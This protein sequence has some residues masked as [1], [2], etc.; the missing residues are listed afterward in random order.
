MG[1]ENTKAWPFEE[2]RGLLKRVEAQGKEKAIIFETGY[3]PSGLPHIGTFGEV[4][5]TSM[6]KHAFEKLSGYAT[7][8]FCFSDDMDGLRK[9]PENIPNREKLEAFRDFPLT[10]VPDPFGKYPSFGEHNNAMLRD[11]LDRFGFSYTFKSAT[12][13][14][15][16]GIF[17]ETLIDVLRHHKEILDILLPT[18]GPE[19]RATYSP[20]LPISPRTGRVLQVAMLEYRVQDGT[21]VFED[22]DGKRVEVPVTGGHCKLQWKVDW[23]MRWKALGIS[24]EMAGKDLIS[25]VEISGKVCRVL[26]GVPPSGCITEHFL[27]E[28]GGKISKSKGNGLSME[29]WL[30]YAPAESLAYFM[31]VTPKRAKRLGFSVIPRSVDEYLDYMKAY[32]SQSED[33]RYENPVWHM[34]QGTPPQSAFELPVNFSMLLN[35]ASVCNASSAD[36]LWKFVTRYQPRATPQEMPFL[37][38]LI[39]HA[40]TYYKDFVAPKKEYRKPTETESY[41]LEALWKALETFENS[42]AYAIALSEGGSEKLGQELQHVVYEVGKEHYPNQLREWFT[43][44]YN[45]ILG[46]KEGPRMG[47]F[48]AIYGIP[49]TCSLI[50]KA[51]AGG[52]S[53]H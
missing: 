2:A 43:C 52:C 51:L 27:D 9:I 17:D 29:E 18:L 36:I 24:Y 35:L 32:A 23:G 34:H 46:Q 4:A 49:E 28:D 50:R 19:R 39:H 8:L 38:T 33:E 22:E 13:C 14:Y 3:G 47:S 31:Y 40:V 5:R 15:T 11:F 30:T 37:D 42:P 41:A 16:Q 6:V 25:S 45:V 44:L 1:F 48:I 10:R 7:E 12:E 21:V 53:V 26:G 20:F